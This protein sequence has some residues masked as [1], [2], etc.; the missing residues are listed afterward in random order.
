MILLELQLYKVLRYLMFT[1][2]FIMSLSENGSDLRLTPELL[3]QN[4]L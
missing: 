2:L 3:E 4:K 1:R